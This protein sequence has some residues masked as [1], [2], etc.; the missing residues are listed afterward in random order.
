MCATS[1]RAPKKLPF[2]TAVRRMIKFLFKIARL[3]LM[4]FIFLAVAAI[5][6]PQKILCVDSGPVKADVIVI[7]G[8]GWHDRPE[9]AAELFKKRAAPRIIV[10]GAGDC[11][12]N[13]RA[14]IEAG[15]PAGV[16][17]LENQSHTTEENARFTIKLL[18]EQKLNRVIIVTSWYHSRR[19]LGTFQHFA[20]EI[21]FYSR[22]S[23]F[24]LARKDWPRNFIKRIYL[25]YVKLPGY[26]IRY[27]V[28]PF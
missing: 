27:G 14:L 25:E 13:R 12:I 7:L 6:F 11:E 26:W 23:Y 21:K 10:S 2:S 5:F 19:A 22:P 28:R 9:R 8:G 15:V 1:C 4:A 16:I 17:E 24:A 20:P 3:V 18:R